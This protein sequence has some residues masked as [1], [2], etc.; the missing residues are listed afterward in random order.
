MWFN[1]DEEE[2]GKA[3]VAPV[4]KSK[5]EDDF[6]DT[7]EKFM[8]TKKG[9]KILNFGIMQHLLGTEIISCL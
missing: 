6:P 9:T 3:V 4:E 5:P 7:Y 2:E 1:E 8:E